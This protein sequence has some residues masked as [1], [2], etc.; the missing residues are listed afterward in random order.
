MNKPKNESTL[1]GTMIVKEYSDDFPEELSTFSFS[2][3][4]GVC[5]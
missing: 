2:V 1:D 3:R 5:V 4:C